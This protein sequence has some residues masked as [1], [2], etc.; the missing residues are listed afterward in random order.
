MK[1]KV[2]F[3]GKEGRFD[4]PSFCLFENEDLQVEFS[5][6]FTSDSV[7]VLMLKHGEAEMQVLL[8]SPCVTIPASWL[9]K[10]G[11]EPI[12][13]NLERRD[14]SACC[15]YAS[16]FIEPLLIQENVIETKYFGAWQKLET[17]DKKL[18]S[19]VES[20]TAEVAELKDIVSGIPALIEKAKREAIVEANGGDPM[21]A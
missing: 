21:S 11:N 17:E 9:L 8:N 18:A 16:F 6:P 10:G 14:K 7:Y 2:T 4:T 19:K 1:R 5:L 3:I 13:F 15:V 20:L 12:W